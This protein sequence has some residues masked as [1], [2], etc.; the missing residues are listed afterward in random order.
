MV[1]HHAYLRHRHL[2]RMKNLLEMLNSS[3]DL[4]SIYVLNSNS[5]IRH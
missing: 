3:L 4:T 5:E 1:I 2:D